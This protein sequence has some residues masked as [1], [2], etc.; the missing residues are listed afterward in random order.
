METLIK[1]FIENHKESLNRQIEGG[2][3]KVRKGEMTESEYKIYLR[4]TFQSEVESLLGTK[5]DTAIP[6]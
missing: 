1:H 5:F 6:N 2:K 3:E 4:M